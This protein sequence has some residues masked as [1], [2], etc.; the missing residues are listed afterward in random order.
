[1]IRGHSDLQSDALPLSYTPF[2]TIQS[3]NQVEIDDVEPEVFDQLLRIIYFTHLPLYCQNI[4]IIK[5]SGEV[6]GLAV[7]Q[8]IPWRKLN[9]SSLSENSVN[10]PHS[11][12]YVKS[13]KKML[14]RNGKV[15]ES[16]KLKEPYMQLKI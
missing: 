16:R 13:R 9:S 11:Q 12:S 14:S 6:K 5:L 15:T 3:T 7:R 2:F 1:M 10:F 4:K 8:T